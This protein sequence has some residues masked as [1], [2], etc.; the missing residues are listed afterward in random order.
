[1]Q[2]DALALI[3]NDYFVAIWKIDVDPEDGQDGAKH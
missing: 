2:T 3:L 1:M